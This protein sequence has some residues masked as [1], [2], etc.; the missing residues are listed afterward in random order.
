MKKVLLLFAF[1]F[2]AKAADA[3]L[4]LSNHPNSDVNGTYLLINNTS[5]T[6]P[7]GTITDAGA[8][9]YRKTIVNSV[10]SGYYQIYRK[11]NFWFI[12]IYFSYSLNNAFYS[13]T[14]PI[15]TFQ[16]FTTSNNPPCETLWSYS[17]GN[18]VYGIG[19]NH[20]LT[21]TGVSC[22][23]PTYTGGLVVNPTNIQFPQLNPTAF[24]SIVPIK[25]ML[26]FFADE[27]ALKVYDGGQ[28]RTL[29]AL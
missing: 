28:W 14:T 22:Y 25:G 24:N 3:Q 1:V 2:L 29:Q 21:I 9:Y 7:D 27:N 6:L 18:G 13:Q 19:A 12:S 10:I 5:N 11:N 26:T 17:R 16:Y 4:E 15:S 20:I 8:D 23:Q